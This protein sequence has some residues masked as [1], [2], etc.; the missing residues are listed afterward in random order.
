MKNYIILLIITLTFS[1]Q[2]TAQTNKKQ[3]AV[4][5]AKPIEL[6]LENGKAKAYFASGC[7]WCVEAV[8]E[9]IKGVDEV[10]NGYSGGHTDNPT[11]AASNTGSTGHAEAVEV[12]YDPKVVSFATLVDAYFASQNPTQVNGQ[13]PDRGSQ[14]RSIIFYQNDSQ[15]KIILEKKEALA[16][17]LDAKIA[18]EVYP[19]QKFWIGE[20]YHQNYER[21]H[22]NNSYIR[23]VSIPRL[24]RFQA[25]FPKALLKEKH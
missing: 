3:E 20:D 14:Y 24:K 12:I 7:F 10:I 2:N 21:L 11:Y 15:K 23:N 5:N 18:A 17:K 9:S 13:G 4:I 25:N 6:P 16:K 1:C 19:F 8:Y 22:P